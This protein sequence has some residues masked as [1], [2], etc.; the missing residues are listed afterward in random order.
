MPD[1]STSVDPERIATQADFGRELKTLRERAGLKIREVAKAS[2]IAVATT[3]DYFSGRHLPS[4]P[5][6]TPRT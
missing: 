3:G 6:P 4:D 5:Q 1:D 2:G